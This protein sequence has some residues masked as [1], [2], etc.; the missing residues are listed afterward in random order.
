MASLF[1]RI[2]LEA[3]LLKEGAAIGG[4]VATGL[5]FFRTSIPF[6]ADQVRNY[7]GP[8][9]ANSQ[10]FWIMFYLGVT[11]GI[12]IDAIFVS[13]YEANARKNFRGRR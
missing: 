5:F 9:T 4:L 12:I 13:K 1:R 6:F 8:F 7:F 2:G 11:L 3:G 10:L